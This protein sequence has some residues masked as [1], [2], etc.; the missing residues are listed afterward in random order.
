MEYNTVGRGID[1]PHLIMF[2]KNWMAELK[3][4]KIIISFENGQMTYLEER[5]GH[6]EI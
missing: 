3:F 6:K 5:I 2:I 4:G 1:I